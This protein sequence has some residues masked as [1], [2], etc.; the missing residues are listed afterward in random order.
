MSVRMPAC[1]STGVRFWASS[2]SCAKRSK[3]GSNSLRWNGSGIFSSTPNAI[4]SGS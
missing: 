2:A 1:S 3:S 4:V